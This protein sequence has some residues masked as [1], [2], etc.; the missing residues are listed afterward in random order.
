MKPEFIGGIS[1]RQDFLTSA[2]CP[3][4]MLQQSQ[5]LPQFIYGAEVVLRMRT[6][7]LGDYVALW[8]KF[9]SRGEG[10]WNFKKIGL[11]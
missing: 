7:V 4:G 9:C 5:C 11:K 8:L 2:Q 1:T 6:V 3:K 10:E